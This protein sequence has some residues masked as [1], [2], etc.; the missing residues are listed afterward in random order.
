MKA[1]IDPDTC[2]GCGLCATSC[3]EVFEMD[4]DAGVAVVKGDGVPGECQD[5]IPAAA[6]ECPVSAITF[7]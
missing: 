1:H 6:E 5:C 7:E 3:P 4:D 2:I